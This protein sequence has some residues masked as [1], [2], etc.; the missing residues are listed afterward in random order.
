MNEQEQ[1]IADALYEGIMR[2]SNDSDRS[3][4][5]KEFKVGV[6]D[7]GFCS[8]RV[9]RMID[10]QVPDDTD[11]L[12]A[13]LG[14]AIGEYLERV[15]K[16]VWPDA[17]VQQ[18]VALQLKGEQSVYTIPGHPDVILPKQGILLDGKTVDGLA[19][20]ERKGPSQQQQ[21]QRH[22]YALAAYQGGLFD[23]KISLDDVQVGNVWVDRSGNDK[24]LHVDLEP[25][26]PEQVQRAGDWLDEAVYWYKAGEEAP[27]EP[28]REMC[29]VACGFYGVCRVFDTDVTGLIT[30]PDTLEAVEMYN[31]G[32]EMAKEGERLRSQAKKLLEGVS[33][34]T[35]THFVRWTSVG[36]SLV[37]E[38]RRR[39]YEKLE[40]V[41]IPK[42]QG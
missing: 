12:A 23:R 2:F 29:K 32:R 17:L 15:A 35:G 21:F 34:S 13:F 19:D 42:R 7:L 22:C 5:A 30:H 10:G 8:E 37:P 1:E 9:R 14:T 33:G 11:T 41:R 39:G 4:Q 31:E 6:S 40:V 36:E 16:Q 26:D 38:T 18:D 20:V 24:R 28:P 3:L 25:F 27:K